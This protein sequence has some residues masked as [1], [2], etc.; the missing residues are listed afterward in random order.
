[1]ISSPWS[2]LA[3]T[4]T[5]GLSAKP[6]QMV[7]HDYLALSQVVVRVDNNY[8]LRSLTIGNER[9]SLE[10]NTLSLS[11]D[12]YPK[13]LI[14]HLN[15][16]FLKKF[17]FVLSP[18]P[19]LPS[20]SF[21]PHPLSSLSPSPLSL[22]LPLSLSLSLS[23]LPIPPPLSLPLSLSPPLLSLTFLCVYIYA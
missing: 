4:G 6:E 12:P 15:F 19:S 8:K 23:P 7:Q 18:S 10:K 17:F 3:P 1:M 5:L 16:P 22:F 21:S 9:G 11:I 14:F 13:I 2:D 20:P